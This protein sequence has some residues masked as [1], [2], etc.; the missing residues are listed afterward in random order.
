VVG[1]GGYIGDGVARAF[2]RAGYRVYGV[3]RKEAQ[4]AHLLA[5]EIIPVKG[6]LK[7]PQLYEEIIEECSVIVDAVY[8]KEASPIFFNFVKNVKKHNVGNYKALYIMTSGIMIY[9]NNGDSLAPKTEDL[10]PTPKDENEMIP[11]KKLEDTVLST[12]ELRTVVIRPG[13]V[14]GG[15]GGVILPLFFDVD[16]KKKEIGAVGKPEKRW[17]WVHVDDLGEAYVKVA[18]AGSVVNGQVFNVSAQDN[19]TYEDLKFVCAKVAGWQGTK[20]DIKYNP[21]VTNKRQQ[22]WETNV[23]INPQKAYDLLGWKPAYVGVL[24]EADIYYKTWKATQHR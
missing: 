2:R 18:Q 14:Y 9:H 16:P 17:S 5:N 15:H 11:K 22:N 4:E 21:E 7:D 8:D 23:I 20:G 10:E 19:P 24:N 12:T 6:D 13:F 3:V 1:A